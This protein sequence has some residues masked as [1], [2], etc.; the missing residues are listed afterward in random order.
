MNLKFKDILNKIKNI[1][2]FTVMAVSL[3]A[4]RRTVD[5]DKIGKRL[6]ELTLEAEQKMKKFDSM[7]SKL[8]SKEENLS[9]IQSKLV[10]IHGRVEQLI[11]Q[12]QKNKER[13]TEY[14]VS[15][16]ENA[17]LIDNIERDSLEIL[18]RISIEINEVNTNSGLNEV[19]DSISNVGSYSTSKLLD[20]NFEHIYS[21]LSDLSS[22]QLGALGHIFC[23][24]SLYYCVISI[25]SSFYGD[26]ILVKFKLEER[27]P[28]LAR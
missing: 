18:S 26:V 20:N 15:P 1:T 27:Y 9:V 14:E 28:R 25:A 3:D 16:E 13:I 12:L 5:S 21:I 19:M 24:L 2:S 10:G 11:N 6:I 22:A 4:Y 7:Q 8:I 23:A 17:E